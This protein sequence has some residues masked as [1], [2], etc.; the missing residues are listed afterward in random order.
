MTFVL[1]AVFV[2]VACAIIVPIAVVYSEQPQIDDNGDRIACFPLIDSELDEQFCTDHGCKWDARGKNVKCFINREKYGYEVINTTKTDT[3]FSVELGWR[4]VSSGFYSDNHQYA[5]FEV[6]FYSDEMLRFSIFPTGSNLENLQPPVPLNLPKPKAETKKYEVVF[7]QTRKNPFE[8]QIVRS[9]T[10]TILLDTSIGGVTVADQFLMITYKLASAYLYGIGE[11]T[12][13]S[14][15]HDMNY[16]MWPIFARDQPPGDGEMNLYGSHPFYMVS[17][18]DGSSH[19][20][21]LFN[22]HAI[23]VTTLPAPALTFRTIGGA[24]DFF[25]FLGPQPEDVVKQYTQLIGRPM[26]PPYYG[27]G[28]QLCKY[29]YQSVD[30]IKEVVN[31]TKQ[32]KIPQ[33]IQYADIDYMDYN[34]DFTFGENFTQ[35]PDYVSEADKS[36][37]RFILILDHVINTEKEN[38]DTH[39]LALEHDVYMKWSNETLKPNGNCT[40]SPHDCQSLH[41][42]MLGYLWPDGKIAIPNF[43]KNET[44]EWWKNEMAKFYNKVKFS[45]IWLDMNEPSNFDTNME[46]PFNWP[47]GKESWNLFCPKNKWDDPPYVPLSA[48]HTASGR[49]SDKTFCMVGKMGQNEEKL[50]YELHNVFGWSETVATHS[51]LEE[52]TKKRTLIISR[53]TFASSGKYAGHWLGDNTARWEDMHSSIIGLMEFNMFGIPYVGADICG[54]MGNTTDALCQRWME[55]GAFY[56]FSRNHNSI[57]L[58]DQDPASLSESVQNA[59]R[60]ALNIR[61]KLLP[62]LY[63]LFYKSH[64]DGNTVVRPL[65]HEFPMDFEAKKIDKQFLWGPALL[66][67]PVLVENEVELEAYMPNATWY[68]YYTEEKVPES[69]IGHTKIYTP[70]DKIN[71]HIRGGNILPTQEGDTP[72]LNTRE[73]RKQPFGLIVA[74]DENK[75]ADGSLFWDDGESI[76]T[77][78][79]GQYSLLRYEFSINELKQSASLRDVVE[80]KTAVLNTIRILGFDQE[81]KSVELDQTILPKDKYR[82]DN[83]SKVLG[84]TE[85]QLPLMNDWTIKIH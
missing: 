76:D 62:Y 77:I 25:I 61:Y 63:T 39:T 45:G 55:L 27:L 31:R 32:A 4:G 7:N 12:H 83:A 6:T 47:D 41:D 36:G 50:H 58:M 48:K 23:D 79:N 17:E 1:L 74:L 35:L 15:V 73:S 18:E 22:S 71:L 10:Q 70:L 19:G 51:I 46:K 64:T 66:I 34:A 82:Y 68:D 24:L 30:E 38:Y 84:F 78:T 3:G 43:F 49:L 67:S 65:Y 69:S 33:D 5:T 11:N 37:L 13:K 16:K 42:I 85:L 29:G 2:I 8:F 21:F 44:K 54:F 59:S 26:I 60:K 14:F 9:S 72:P 56:P 52:V 28:F 40:V 53:S 80:L 57:G 20:V 81:P 75:S